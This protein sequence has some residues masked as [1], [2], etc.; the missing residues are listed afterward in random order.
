MNI[1]NLRSA[2]S[3]KRPDTSNMVY[4]Q[5]AVGYH[6][7]DPAIYFK[8]N[9]DSLVKIGPVYVG[10]T[11]PN[12][13]PGAGGTTGNAKGEMWLDTSLTPTRL[14]I[15]TGSAWDT[16]YSGSEIKTLYE[17]EADTNAFTDADHT[18]LDSIETSAT[19]DQTAAEI[20][21]LL[22]DASSA[23]HGLL[24]TTKHDKI[25]GIETGATADQSD[26]EIKTAY[27]AN[28]DT[29][30]L[31]DARASVV[32]A[33]TSNLAGKADL[34][35]GVLDVSQLPDLAI[36]VFKGTVANQ[37][38]ML[39]I[40]GEQGDWVIRSD[41]GMVYVITGANPASA[42]SWTALSY[43]AAPN[44]NLTYNTGTRILSS[45]T[46][47]DVTLPEA[48]SAIPGLMS[49]SKHDKLDGIETGATADQTDAQ[50][51][52]AYEANSN[53]NAFTDADH[54]KLDGIETAAT[55][56]QTAAEI[57][58]LVESAS[59]SNVFTD[60]DHVK[61]NGIESS[62]TADQTAAE[63]RTL[64][65]DA[66]SLQHGLLSTAKHDKLDLIE[67]AATRDQTS[68]EIRALVE[69]AADSNVFT[70]ADHTKLNG[71]TA[72]A[73]LITNTSQLTN[74]SGYYNVNSSSLRIADVTQVKF[75][76]VNL[77]H[78]GANRFTLVNDSNT[79]VYAA[80]GCDFEFFNSHGGYFGQLQ[81]LGTTNNPSIFVLS[82]DTTYGH[83][84]NSSALAFV[85][86]QLEVDRMRFHS[87]HNTTT[88]VVLGSGAMTF[89]TSL[90]TNS[91]AI[92]RSAL[93][94]SSSNNTGSDNV[95]VGYAAGQD[96]T[97]GTANTLVGSVAGTSINTGS[98]NT[99]IGE[100]AGSSID[101]GTGH[102]A[103]GYR[104]LRNFGSATSGHT[105][106]GAS[107]SELVG[108]GENGTAVGYY[109][110]YWLQNGSANNTSYD[111]YTC[112]GH[113]SSISGDN[114]VQLGDSATTT[115][116]YGSVQNRS[117]ARDKSDVRDTLLGLDFIKSLR[118][119]DFRWDMRD[120]YFNEIVVDEEYE[121]TVNELNPDYV[122]GGDEPK[123]IEKVVTRVRERLELEP[124][125]RDG[126]KKRS[127]FHHGLIAQEVKVAADD[128]GVDF[129][130][131][132][133]HAVGGGLDV[134]TIGYEEL[135]APMIKAIQEQQ[136]KIEL[137]ESKL[138]ALEGI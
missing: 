53:T 115:Y 22:G 52:T 25:D 107:A 105:A 102:T 75:E 6:E 49:S 119:V 28:A 48:S 4:G 120:D 23:Q 37:V 116:V 71:I 33:V 24:S 16:M 77:T 104:A 66:S 86:G 60:A 11:A 123:Y 19:A 98:N 42:G 69:A 12:A 26:A 14:K 132:Q 78:S 3:S 70:D 109:A 89:G 114:Q 134:L 122:K 121:D 20:R 88:N 91:V 111:N 40:T 124:I 117:D 54:N 99:C 57:R 135:I 55:A 27:E 92:G 87:G 29:N 81:H 138:D 31:T 133:D 74:G 126:S 95:G 56:D 30:A 17:G 43:P 34:V 15:Y 63:I 39:A 83:S 61:L 21:T 72:G 5:L 44:T 65:G 76:G 108:Q 96:V 93:R 128:L 85:D 137:L 41:D 1:Q 90:A 113:N 130:G 36:T 13:T 97:N 35:G 94:G 46:G 112:L 8:A 127:R 82:D 62:A 103:I 73:N 68:T 32:D 10:S 101:N 45:S 9:D 64:L 59:D 7:T 38:A 125:E 51:K 129:A 67:S 118:P 50:I 58:T 136:A 84:S 106:L 100:R 18:K 80:F 110:N 47:T 131:Y 2:T 79:R